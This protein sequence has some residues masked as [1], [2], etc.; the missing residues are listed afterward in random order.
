M[1]RRG[2]GGTPISLFSFQDII[3]SVTGIMI[4]VT[5]IL[6]LEVIQKREGS[7]QNRTKQLTTELQTAVQQ[8]AAMQV[9]AAAA[10]A[11]ID[12]LRAT[13]QQS[14]S[15]LL[16]TVKV[17]STQAARSLRDL[18]EL[19][20]LLA[21]ELAQSTRRA[22]EA[23]KAKQNMEAEQTTKSK[24]K[25]TLEQTSQTVQQKLEE[26]RKLRAANRVIFNLT[27]SG[28]K[29]AWLVELGAEKILAA[30]TGKKVPAQSFNTPGAF[31]AW[32][33]KRNRASE[34]FVLLVKP[35]TIQQFEV[36]RD[37]LEKANFDLGFDLL[38]AD[39]TAIDPQTGAAAP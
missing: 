20:K 27:Q 13:L 4:L 16:E 35:A 6:A 22:Q 21:D 5:L 3:T 15:N 9:T 19:N 31:V 1:S 11:E 34:Y 14:E 28:P 12:N 23:D 17:D 8:T 24:D 30:E 39:Q 37:A 29:A 26:L 36:V 32:A 38:K 10:K 18:E 2:R 7:P 25:V 33:K